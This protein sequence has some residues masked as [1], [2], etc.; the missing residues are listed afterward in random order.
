MSNA[1][2]VTPYRPVDLSPA[3]QPRQGRKK[4]A[5]E[6]SQII[7]WLVQRSSAPA[8]TQ[9]TSTQNLANPKGVS[10]VELCLKGMES[11]IASAQRLGYRLVQATERIQ[12]ERPISLLE[13]AQGQRLVLEQDEGGQVVAH[14]NDQVQT[15]H[16]L[17][18][19]HTLD[20]ARAHLE[21]KGMA[22]T[23]RTLA[24]G[25]IEISAIEPISRPD[26]KAHITAH[27]DKDGSLGLDIAHIQGTRCEELR[28]Q[29]AVAI[30]GQVED[31]TRKAEYFQPL[32]LSIAPQVEV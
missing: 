1:S 29:L 12:Y 28:N 6:V 32:G 31:E 10:H 14:V 11:L 18:R 22:V 3:V 17:V 15:L 24:N 5:H 30:G 21:E 25:E 8:K 16:T 4:V 19:Q 23:T 27:I 7:G 26:G 9:T 2:K 13:N 20:A